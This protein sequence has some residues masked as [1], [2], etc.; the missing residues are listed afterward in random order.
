MGWGMGVFNQSRPVAYV[1][2]ALTAMSLLGSGY[3]YG[4][5]ERLSLELAEIDRAYQLSEERLNQTRWELNNASAGLVHLYGENTRL[6]QE[7][8]ELNGSY[9]SMQEQLLR[10]QEELDNASRRLA[11]LSSREEVWPEERGTLIEILLYHHDCSVQSYEALGVQL[12]DLRIEGDTSPLCSFVMVYPEDLIP[13][14]YAESILRICRQSRNEVSD[15][16]GLTVRFLNKQVLVCVFPSEFDG[17]YMSGVDDRITLILASRTDLT[18]YKRNYV[19]GFIHEVAHFYAFFGDEFNQGWA[20]YAGARVYLDVV[21]GLGEGVWP[22]E[23]DFT[24]KVESFWSVIETGEEPELRAARVLL[25]IDTLYG[26]RIIGDAL[27]R[28]P[29]TW[30][31]P[32]VTWTELKQALIEV[33]GEHN[34]VTEIFVRNN[35][36]ETSEL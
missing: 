3:L 13:D 8:V 2:I 22:T 26:P 1:L 5:N 36:E 11:E 28:I 30:E 18:E 32:G 4:E 12:D 7:L 24:E 27:R 9:L 35:F 19:Y 31:D 20:I 34:T 6:S 15:T 10:I 33:T 25:E 17:L 23:V 16:F 29:S 14:D 21:D